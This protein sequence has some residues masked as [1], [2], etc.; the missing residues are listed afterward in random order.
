M[1][2]DKFGHHVHKRL[3]AVEHVQGDINLNSSRLKGLKSPQ[4]G[5]EAAN[6]DYVDQTTKPFCTKQELNA[7]IR[8]IKIEIESLLV[9]YSQKHYTK[10]EINSFMRSVSKQ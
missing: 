2:I 7:E 5:D 9:Q 1:N 8:K 6:K 10:S 3:R 4:S